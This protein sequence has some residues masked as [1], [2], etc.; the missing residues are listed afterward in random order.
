MQLVHNAADVI[1]SELR[2][3]LGEGIQ[4]D[5]SFHQHGPQ[6]QFGNYGLAFAVEM[7]RWA[8]VLR[9]SPVALPQ[10]KLTILRD[11]LL[12]GQNWVTWRGVMDI[13][14]CG[15][16][17]FPHGPASRANSILA[18]MSTL[19]AVDPTHADA[20][21]EFV[22][23]N[24]DREAQNDLQGF[25]YFWCS[26]YAVS[27][28]SDLFFTVRMHSP[29]TVGGESLNGENL[30]GALLSDGAM[31]TYR[32][33]NEY[34][35]IFPVWD[36]R[37]IP[38][39]TSVQSATPPP[40]THRAKAP[41][42]NASTGAFT[43]GVSDGHDGCV[44]MDFSRD[45]LHAKKAWFFASDQVVCL[46]T[47]IRCDANPAVQTTIDQCLLHGPVKR[48]TTEQTLTG[49]QT[50]S[51]HAGDA[52]EH[53]GIR[54]TALAD[55][56]WAIAAEPRTGEW[57]SVFK[58]PST[59]PGTVTEPALTLSIPHGRQPHDASY[60]YAVASPSAPLMHVVSNTE[61]LQAVADTDGNVSAVFWTAGSVPT[62]AGVVSTDAQCTVRIDLQTKMIFIADPTQKLPSI[63]VGVG[64]ATMPVTLPK[65]PLAG[66]SQSHP[67]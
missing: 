11:Y 41:P 16:Q 49:Q 64:N 62:A 27:R 9:D 40:W 37:N 2:V 66:S 47:A 43:G 61:A 10:A 58:N 20:Y 15:R 6:L 29:R 48:S 19:P 65:G 26:D 28:G 53:N 57:S 33:S 25:R 21:R 23:R 24:D 45:S 55:A 52:I 35:E 32:T 42:P 36:W 22:R 59:P 5:D 12:G 51:L 17:L 54:Y 18:V 60:A 34:T 7:C 13:S 38:G 31:F 3:G 8:V 67:F 30:L 14:S 1:W 50:L 39:I 56:R 44:A 46:G 4:P 63:R